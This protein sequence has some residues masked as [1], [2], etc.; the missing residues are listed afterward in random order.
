MTIR[1]SCHGVVVLVKWNERENMNIEIG[2][3]TRLRVT[4]NMR[5]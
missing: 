3:V 5:P 4:L 1:L 2:H